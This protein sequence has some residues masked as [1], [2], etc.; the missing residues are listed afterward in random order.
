VFCLV[1]A[2]QYL[3]LSGRAWSRCPLCFEPVYPQALKSF[4]F[5]LQ[6]QRP[7][8]GDALQMALIMRDKHSA[9]L[10]L[11][12]A[13]DG[14]SSPTA[15]DPTLFS[16]FSFT[17]DISGICYRELMELAAAASQHRAA[18][19]SQRP[20]SSEGCD[21]GELY[22]QF[23]LM[24]QQAVQR[25]LEDWMAEHPDSSQQVRAVL[26]RAQAVRQRQQVEQ[27]ERAAQQQRSEREEKERQRLSR[28][29]AAPSHRPR[30]RPTAA[31]RTSGRRFP[32]L[33]LSARCSAE[34]LRASRTWQQSSR[35]HSS[36]SSSRRRRCLLKQLLHYSQH[37]GPLP[38]PPCSRLPRR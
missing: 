30:L 9:Q 5:R 10:Q 4:H 24:A 23:V 11:S 25:R 12:A 36:S 21:D 3:S 38:P 33:V 20:T 18:V 8:T 22:L 15:A 19:S 16:R 31:T 34:R 14:E 32:T 2:L 1:C 7:A 28:V 13:A 35:R 37:T 6:Q 27:E 26:A 17:S 29:R